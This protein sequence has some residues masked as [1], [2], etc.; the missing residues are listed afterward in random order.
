MIQTWLTWRFSVDNDCE[1][2]IEFSVFSHIKFSVIMYQL[3]TDRLRYFFCT[4]TFD[5]QYTVLWFYMKIRMFYMF[6]WWCGSVMWGGLRVIY[7]SIYQRCFP[8]FLHYLVLFLSQAFN[9]TSS[10]IASY[11]TVFSLSQKFD[12]YYVSVFH[13]LRFTLVLQNYSHL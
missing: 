6:E 11:F 8:V 12:C 9:I 10:T 1:H 3:F 5:V 13:W 4:G 7:L 2:S